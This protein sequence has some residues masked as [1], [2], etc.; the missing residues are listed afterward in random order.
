MASVAPQV[1]V[2][3]VAGSI[4]L[5]P[6]NCSTVEVAIASRRFVAPQVIAY[7]LMSSWIA[8]AAA[9][10]S[11]CGQAKSGKP[12]ARL[13]APASTASRFI[14]RMTDSV[15]LAALAKDPGWLIGGRQAARRA[16]SSPTQSRR[17]G[18]G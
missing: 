7:W 10:L 9:S 15:K 14:S 8:F 18:R 4:S 5:Q 16:T 11:S 3:I 1:T 17:R 13:T 2:I 6:G 12:W